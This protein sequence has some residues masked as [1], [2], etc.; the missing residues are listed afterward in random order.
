MA[1]EPYATGTGPGS[2]RRE[3]A[4]TWTDAELEELYD[5]N[6]LRPENAMKMRHLL[7]VMKVIRRCNKASTLDAAIAVTVENTCKIM[8]CDRATLFIVDER[9]EELVLRQAVGVKDIRLPL[10]ESSIAGAVYLSGEKLNIP[11]AYDS[12]YFNKSTDQAT[13]YKTTSI[14]CTP[15][16]DANFEPVAVLQAVNKLS[17]APDGD[18]DSQAAEG[19]SNTGEQS[20]GFTKL[21]EVLMDH[22]SLQLGIILRNQMLRE[23]SEI[24]H[25]QVLSMVDIVR[26]LHSKMGINSLIFTVTERSPSLVDAERCTLY[27]VDR[28]HNEL[29]SIQGAVEIRTTCDKGLA[30]YTATTGEIINIEDA[31]KDPRFNTEFDLKSGFKTKSVLVM[32]ITDRQVAEDREAEV[33]GVL[34]LI[35]KVH[36]HRFTE[37][38]EHLLSSFLDIV[39]GHMSSSQLFASSHQSTTTEFG[40]AQDIAGTGSVSPM[41]P[42]TRRHGSSGNVLYQPDSIDE[43][44]EEDEDEDDDSGMP[45]GVP[46]T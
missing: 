9:R 33:I 30:G 35:N 41:P 10:D 8:N 5:V 31:H 24:R 13:G 45:L 26:S 29:M 28:K 43:I 22:L 34:Q 25:R 27:V 32:P 38:D 42:L 15:I 36:G 17:D 46:M 2:R 14:L 21:D 3:R 12:P 6:A 16:R 20:P 7:Q 1:A 19:S 40:A 37:E 18:S 44:Q 4:A 23:A 11:D 39:G